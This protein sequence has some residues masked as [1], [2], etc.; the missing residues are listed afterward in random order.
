MRFFGMH[1]LQI[2]LTRSD[3]PTQMVV[4]PCL[5][6]EN[7][8]SWFLIINFYCY[9][10]R[11]F[12]FRERSWPIS[13]FLNMLIGYIPKLP[14]LASNN[15]QCEM[16]LRQN[17]INI[18]HQLLAYNLRVYALICATLIWDMIHGL[19]MVV[20]CAVFRLVRGIIHVP[21]SWFSLLEKIST[22]AAIAAHQ[23]LYSFFI[24]FA[25]I[26]PFRLCWEFRISSALSPFMYTARFIRTPE[27]HEWL[28]ILYSTPAHGVHVQF[29][30]YIYSY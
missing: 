8:H 25:I 24:F 1:F 27:F 7:Q 29:S 9:N 12:S 5:H 2:S 28:K 13:D 26:I 19:C 22:C 6:I 16:Q 18:C 10:W 4:L 3:I 15:L 23:R 14:K 21:F 17:S 20:V 11:T 30:S